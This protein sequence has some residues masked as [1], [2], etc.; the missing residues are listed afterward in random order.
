MIKIESLVAKAKLFDYNT[1][2]I[3][4]KNVMH[5]YLKFNN[6][7]KK[8][9][10]K[11]VFGLEVT[12]LIDDH[13]YSIYLYAKNDNG[14]SNLSKIST[15]INLGNSINLDNI[16][17]YTENCYVVIPS[18][19][20]YFSNLRDRV[21]LSDELVKLK[22]KFD[23]L[24]IGLVNNDIKYNLEYNILIKECCNSIALSTIAFNEVFYLD[25]DDAY[26]YKV[27][28][29]IKQQKTITDNDLVQINGRFFR[30]LYEL[31]EL[32]DVDDINNIKELLLNCNVSMNFKKT[33]LPK[34]ITKNEVDSKIY[35][36][37]LCEYGLN[38]RLNGKVYQEY[39][40]RLN[41]ELNIIISMHFEDYFLIVYDFI[42]FA[43]KK[44]IYVG[45][46]RGSAAGSLVSYCL[47]ITHLD[48]IKYGLL[49]ERFLNPER[50]SMP[51]ID[52]DFPDN[53]R[54]EVI[55]YVS[56]K[57]GE[58]HVSHIITFGTLKAKQVLR[59]VSRVLE[60]NTY[61]V[62]KIAKAVPNDLNVTLELAYENS[63]K[64]R[65]IINSDEKNHK[66][67]EIA[68]KLEGLPRHYS[69]HAAGIVI[70]KDKLEDVIP[71]INL[72]N[73]LTTQ[74]TMDYLEDLGLIKM[75]FLGLRNLTIIDEIVQT[76]KLE[77]KDFN[78]MKIPL[79]DKITYQLIQRCN[80]LGVFQLESMG[81][82]NLVQKVKP[83]SLNDIAL[84]L[85]LYR[86]GPMQNIPLY[87]QNRNNPN[88]IIY[89]H[90][91]LKGILEET[92]GVIIYQEQIMII[93]QKMAGFTL[94]K[95]DI[96]R[97]AMSKKKV[98]QLMSLRDEF[99]EG[100]KDNHYTE[101]ISK[102]IYDLILKFANYG[103]NKS[104]SVAYGLISYQMAYLKA[105]YPLYFYQS[106]LNSVISSFDK[107][108]EYINECKRTKTNI[109]GLSINKSDMYYIIEDQSIRFP[110]LAIKGLGYNS[111]Q[112][113]IVERDQNGEY[114]NYS[115]FILR[116]IE[117][118]VSKKV[119]ETLINAGALDEF[120]YSRLSMIASL[121]ENITYANLASNSGQLSIGIDI[122]PKP[123]MIIVKEDA[124]ERAEREREVLGFYLSNN[125]IVYIR[126]K[127][128]IDLEYLIKL[129]N[130]KGYVTGFGVIKKTKTYR[131]K[132]NELM[133]FVS[134][135]DETSDFD[136]AIMPDLLK[137]YEKVI[138][139]GNYIIFN[140]K[141]GDRES[142]LVKDIKIVE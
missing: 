45:P 128:N 75:D 107:T 89:P 134:I 109:L 42:L 101:E 80:V 33:T 90:E 25:K 12:I 78:I 48:P 139:K 67:F 58:E 28:Q 9:N 106:L 127:Y 132:R 81:M 52:T 110:L 36:R 22:H 14:Y 46:G 93:A 111:L 53:R 21:L 50:I 123:K 141:I 104:H 103:F 130:I 95:A 32:Y 5:G 137:K 105:N 85:A 138:K 83:K 124:F 77:N 57:Y 16:T 142:C 61:D 43:R 23:N 86:P 59:D 98:E 29:G 136:L 1:L 30:S 7:C 135:Q 118:G 99:L 47:G 64:F 88:N 51:D 26:A 35:L 94:A 72:D 19:D 140:G 4:D 102:Q 79:D 20:F 100:C 113:I 13:E 87:L 117:A 56:K 74:F 31:Q 112:T 17:N 39:K 69:T 24:Y 71:C 55:E 18:V 92:S 129:K 121:D 120:D 63:N 133:A 10:I 96:L 114:S 38:R 84:T 2:V 65:T 15:F 66:L 3:T 60:F 40:E 122:L 126:D 11:P 62:D 27:L 108:S 8:N 6:L 70:A 115:N 34:F 116:M 131:T 97:K 73:M 41:H 82:K 125:P 37:K 49:F 91:D 44:D 54:D 68:I 76:I 119:I